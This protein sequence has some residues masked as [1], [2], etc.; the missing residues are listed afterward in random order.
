MRP[1]FLFTDYGVTG[2]YVGQ[3]K[4]ALLAQGFAG[5]VIDLMADAPAFDPKASAY[6]LAALLPRMPADAVGLCV[7][8]PG[9]GGDRAALVV[10]ADGRLLVGPDNGLFELAARR[11]ATLGIWRIEWQPDELSATFHGRDLF[12]PVA[13]DLAQGRRP[14]TPWCSPTQRIDR[15][16][17]PNDW[18]VTIY[19][20]GFGNVMTGLRGEA[21]AGDDV[22][23]VNGHR[24]TAARTF[25]DLPPGQP[26]WYVNSVGLV[27]LAVNGGRADQCLGIAG[28]AV[29]ERQKNQDASDAASA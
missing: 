4:A 17:W 13:A 22:L 29:V 1:I 18:A 9:V 3:V 28:R 26:F 2:P 24:L 8:D 20:D 12:A 23:V 6:L 19:V 5:P 11:A 25:S 16:D 15:G 27:E 21:V 10:K 7:V 14:Q